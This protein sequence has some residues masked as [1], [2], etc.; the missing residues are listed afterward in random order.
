MNKLTEKMNILFIITD[1]QRADHLSCMGHPVLRTPHIDSIASEGVRFNKYFSAT[2][3]CMPN[4]ASF[5][6][7]V[8]PSVHKTRSNGINLDP[9][10]PTL[11]AI[12][13]ENGYHT[14][15]F[16]KMHFNF[17]ANSNTKKVQ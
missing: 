4:R 10:I 12:L 14:C 6:T 17:Y 15:S 3:I 11:S 5:F 9:E 16:G 1:Q 13:K 7:G 2:P 8:Y